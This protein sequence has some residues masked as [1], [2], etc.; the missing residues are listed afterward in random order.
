MVQKPASEGPVRR[1][2]G[3][4][5]TRPGS[6]AGFRKFFRT[7]PSEPARENPLTP[8]VRELTGPVGPVTVHPGSRP[9]PFSTT[10]VSGGQVLL[11]FLM[12]S[13]CVKCIWY[14]PTRVFAS[15]VSPSIFF[16]SWVYYTYNKYVLEL[17]KGHKSRIIK[18]IQVLCGSVSIQMIF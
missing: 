1:P 16:T 6:R 18:I 5:P 7:R 15:L 11:F 10:L 2:V 14:G 3:P 13:L 9:G 17:L 8:A 12:F 4:V